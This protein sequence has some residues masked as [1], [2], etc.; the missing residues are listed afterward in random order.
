M[1]NRLVERLLVL[2]AVL[3]KLLYKTFIPDPFNEK[4]VFV[5]DFM[6]FL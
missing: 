5:Y 3:R 4:A 1:M 2:V 6:D